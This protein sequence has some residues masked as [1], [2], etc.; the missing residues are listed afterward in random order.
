M[1]RKELI[2]QEAE[3]VYNEPFTPDQIQVL[4]TS[5]IH[6]AQFADSL[7]RWVK[8]GNDVQIGKIPEGTYMLIHTK[9]G[10]YQAIR[11]NLHAF[12]MDVDAGTY[13]HY[14]IINPPIK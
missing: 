1:T 10:T 4:R 12:L 7:D 5:F 6:G 14:Q 8:V 13:T 3:R 2:E 11:F 9:Q